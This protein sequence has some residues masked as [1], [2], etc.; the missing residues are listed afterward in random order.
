[1]QIDITISTVDYIYFIIHIVS[2]YNDCF[3][4][5]NSKFLLE[6]ISTCSQRAH[7]FRNYCRNIFTTRPFST[8]IKKQLKEKKCFHL[9]S[10]F[11]IRFVVVLVLLLFLFSFSLKNYVE[12]FFLLFIK[13]SGKKCDVR[14][15]RYFYFHLNATMQHQRHTSASVI[16]T[17][18]CQVN[19]KSGKFFF[20]KSIA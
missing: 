18:E 3:K 9:K 15:E 16:H 8:N 5:T 6:F 2:L 12:C 13:F 7:Y 1:M 4:F 14:N 20:C 10:F 11:C 19:G 17:F